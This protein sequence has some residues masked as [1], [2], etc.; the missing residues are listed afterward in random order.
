[1]QQLI[2]Q[3][4]QIKRLLVF[5]IATPRPANLEVLIHQVHEAQVL[6]LEPQ[7]FSQ[8]LYVLRRV[9]VGFVVRRWYG[10]FDGRFGEGD[11][12]GLEDVF[13]QVY[14]DEFE[15]WVACEC[16]EDEVGE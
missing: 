10:A 16:G 6:V 13:L 11:D 8:H 3:L 4:H 1:M 12:G 9:D 14:L 15:F 5:R 7:G 2:R